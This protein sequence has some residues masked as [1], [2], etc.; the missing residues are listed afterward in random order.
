MSELACLEASV[1]LWVVH[2][3]CQAG[4]A[5]SALSLPYLV[6]SRDKPAAPRGP[7]YGRAT[8]ALANYVENFIAFVAY[9]SAPTGRIWPTVWIAARIVCPPLYLF[10]V[11]FFRSIV[12]GVSLI[13][14]WRCWRGWFGAERRTEQARE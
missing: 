4:A 5:Q 12:W 13:A 3:V 6:S 11:I 10:N 8:R 9:R 7:I 2:V 1:L 14:I